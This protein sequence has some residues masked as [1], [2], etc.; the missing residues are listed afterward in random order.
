MRHALRDAGFA[1]EGID[2]ID[3]HG[4]S[5]RLNEAVET[6]AI[7]ELFGEHAYRIL[8][9]STKSMIRHSLGAAGALEAI[10]CI[11]SLETGT[12]HPTINYAA[13]NP[14]CDLYYVPNQAREIHPQTVL[15]NSFAFGGHNGAIIF[16][17]WEGWPPRGLKRITRARKGCVDLTW[18]RPDRTP[19]RL[20]MPSLGGE[21]HSAHPRPGA[22]GPARF[23]PA[24]DWPAGWTRSPKGRSSTES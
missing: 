20:E 7:H 8:V 11:K 15:S 6:G 21:L 9:S 14:D 18:C 3:A 1:P 12:I 4:N 2:Y 24:A 10:A 13:P 17:A 23:G 16:A 5:T 19:T 22:A